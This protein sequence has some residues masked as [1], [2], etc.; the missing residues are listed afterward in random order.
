MPEAPLVAVLA[1]GRATRFGGGKLD[2]PCAGKPLGRWVLEAV[3]QARLPAGIVIGAA[4]GPAFA[5]GSGWDVL[6]NP[7]AD[8][9]L[10]TSLA[11]AARAALAREARALLVLLADMPLVGPHYLRALAAA[12]PPTATRYPD[13][14]P[15][16]PALFGQAQLPALAELHGDRGAAAL[17][18]LADGLTLLKPPAATLRDVDTAADLA[19]IERVLVA[20]K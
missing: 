3:A 16:V 7:L 11:L 6:A 9:G 12:V 4:Q 13:G 19:E 14:D 15:G 17:L 10:G 18:N 1:A 2:A 8:Q 20:G 5:E